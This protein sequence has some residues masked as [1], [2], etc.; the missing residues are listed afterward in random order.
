M[1]GIFYLQYHST[2]EIKSKCSSKSTNA[3]IFNFIPHVIFHA[4][5]I[6]PQNLWHK[7]K[8]LYFLHARLRKRDIESWT[9]ILS[10]TDCEEVEVSGRSIEKVEQMRTQILDIR[11]RFRCLNKNSS[12]FR[13]FSFKQNRTF[14]YFETDSAEFPKC[15]TFRFIKT[16]KVKYYCM[17]FTVVELS[18]KRQI[19]WFKQSDCFWPK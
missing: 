13:F 17:T 7:Y 10:T 5:G 4:S 14:F 18:S 6:K 12:K 1:N 2:L 9:C 16:L 8:L 15:K 11:R 19:S 3:Y